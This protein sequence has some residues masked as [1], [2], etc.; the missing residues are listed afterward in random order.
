[1]ARIAPLPG[2]L[3]SAARSEYYVVLLGL[4]GGGPAHL[5]ID[6]QE[7]LRRVHLRVLPRAP[8]RARPWAVHPSGGLKAA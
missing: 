1:M 4:A 7:V 2:P 6:I 5:A 3:P 8:L